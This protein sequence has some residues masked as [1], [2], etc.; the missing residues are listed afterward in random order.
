MNLRGRLIDLSKMWH[1]RNKM[2]TVIVSVVIALFVIGAITFVI[3]EG[4]RPSNDSEEKVQLSNLSYQ[5]LVS[6]NSIE[7]P[8]PGNHYILVN[9]TVTNNKT[10]S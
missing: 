2:I 8:A 7:Y 9:V 6:N 4:S 10:A 3:L 5:G 1:H